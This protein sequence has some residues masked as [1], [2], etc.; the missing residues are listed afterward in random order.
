MQKEGLKWWI[1]ALIPVVLILVLASPSAWAARNCNPTRN[2]CESSDP[3][4]QSHT[5][6]GGA[7]SVSS[8]SNLSPGRLTDGTEGEADYEFTF[9]RNT[10]TLTL[11]VTNQT[12]TQSTLTGIFFNVTPAVTGLTLLS[13][14]GVLRWVMAFDRIRTD[15]FVDSDHNL[16]NLRGDGFGLFHVFLSNNITD[17]QRDAGNPDIE[18]L[19]GDM[20]TFVFRVSGDLPKITACSFT[21]VGSLVPP[22]DKIQVALGRFQAGV[23]GGSGFIGPCQ[24]GPLAVTLAG[25]SAT[26]GEGRVTLGWSTASESNNAGFRILRKDLR[27]Q[28]IIALNTFMIPS[29]GDSVSGAD[30]SYID[31]TA[32]NGRK[33]HYFLEDWDLEGQNTIHRPELAIPN[34]V[35]PPVRLL[36]PGYDEVA[37]ASVRF[38]WEADARTRFTAEISGDATFPSGKSMKLRAGTRT[39]LTLNTFEMR[40]IARMAR[41]A[42]EGGVYW[43]VTGTDARG[44]AA[45]SQTFF[46]GVQP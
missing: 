45:R 14:D 5:Q 6:I 12:A 25:F 46:V 7:G 22:G 30:Y 35:R 23:Q 15:G 10:A 18:I 2:D 1:G 21:S 11:K 40:Q 43:R 42:G 29:Q 16:V 17:V 4:T 13:E 20:V 38:R 41:A 34:P 31:D 36:S 32:V 33:Y 44:N 28:Q 39:T 37:G 27:T 9:D 3:I 19:P 8:F 24:G 26:P